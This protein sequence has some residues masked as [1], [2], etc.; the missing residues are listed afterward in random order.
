MPLMFGA[1]VGFF[2]AAASA[3]LIPLRAEKYRVS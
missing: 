3:C 2:L 1:L